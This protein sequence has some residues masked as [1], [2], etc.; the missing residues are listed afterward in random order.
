M[1]AGTLALWWA[2]LAVLAHAAAACVL[3]AHSLT[4]NYATEPMA[5]HDPAP[6]LAWKLRV[7]AGQLAVN[8]TQSA[9]RVQAASSLA[10][11]LSGKPD[12]W[13]SGLVRASGWGGEGARLLTF[14][15]IST[16][17]TV[18]L[19]YG[20][21]ALASA[22]RA[23]WRVRSWDGAGSACEWSAPSWWEAGLL[24]ET[25]W[26]GSCCAGHRELV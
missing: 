26:Q 12:L 19:T 5:I 13:D 7:A 9:A 6:R 10:A 14:R 16:A 17:S 21:I 18:A 1:P 8:Q 4:V 11:L 2:A 15:Q 25:D 20:G 22:Q 3:E 24:A 23:Y